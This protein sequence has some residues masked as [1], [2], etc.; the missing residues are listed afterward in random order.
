[1]D[2]NFSA[3]PSTNYPNSLIQAHI[4]RD[5]FS[6]PSSHSFDNFAEI[7]SFQE[8]YFVVEI[9]RQIPSLDEFYQSFHTTIEA[10]CQV[11]FLPLFIS[12]ISLAL[13]KPRILEKT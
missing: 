12:R 4:F 8:I 9:Q 3:H 13:P 7:L 2:S 1:M 11:G 6:T 10:G 5:K